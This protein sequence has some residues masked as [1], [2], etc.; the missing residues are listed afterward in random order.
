MASNRSDGSSPSHKIFSTS[1]IVI[2]AENTVS[3]DTNQG[4]TTNNYESV[5]K[6]NEKRTNSNQNKLNKLQTTVGSKEK[7]IKLLFVILH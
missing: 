3:F 6:R 1:N 5:S 2:G 7:V 4:I